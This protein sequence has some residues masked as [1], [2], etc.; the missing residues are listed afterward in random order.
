MGSPGRVTVHCIY[1]P[2][3][4]IHRRG[5]NSSSNSITSKP[6]GP[7]SCR[8]QAAIISHDSRGWSVGRLVGWFNP[9]RT[10]PHMSVAAG[11][12]WSSQF[13]RYETSIDSEGV[14]GGRQE[15]RQNRRAVP[16]TNADEPRRSIN[17]VS[18]TIG[19]IWGIKLQNLDLFHFHRQNCSSTAC[20]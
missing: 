4:R 10:R 19:V 14:H 16:M 7:C 15:W 1:T 2:H 18:P 11:V 9:V 20:P 17:L 13:P 5:S 12:E 8:K 6:T 3:I